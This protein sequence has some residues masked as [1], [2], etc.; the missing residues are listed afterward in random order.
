[1]SFSCPF[2]WT[3][4]AEYF[5]FYPIFVSFL[6]CLFRARVT[7]GQWR[8]NHSKNSIAADS[9]PSSLVQAPQFHFTWFGSIWCRTIL[10]LNGFWRIVH[11]IVYVNSQ[12]LRV[13][14]NG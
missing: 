3:R 5:V 10:L 12:Q 13:G 11:G 9:W 14:P 6:V 4:Y 8:I 2:Y 1:M 7:C